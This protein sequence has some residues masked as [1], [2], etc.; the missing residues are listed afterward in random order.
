[1]FKVCNGGEHGFIKICWQ[2]EKTANTWEGGVKNWEKNID[3]FYEWWPLKAMFYKN[4]TKKSPIFL[5]WQ[6]YL[7][8]RID[9][10]LFSIFSIL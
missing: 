9:K 7:L 8:R 3:I 2:V 4:M 10:F 5:N 1:M 6:Y